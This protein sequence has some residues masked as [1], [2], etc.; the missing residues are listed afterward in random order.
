MQISDQGLTFHPDGFKTYNVPALLT[1]VGAIVGTMS[2]LVSTDGCTA[3]DT[4]AKLEAVLR[5][6][7]QMR[8]SNWEWCVNHCELDSVFLFR[9]GKCNSSHEDLG[10]MIF[11]HQLVA[12]WSG[13]SCQS[14]CLLRQR[15]RH[16]HTIPSKTL[17]AAKHW[18][19][20]GHQE[21]SWRI[22]DTLW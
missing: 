12:F 17:R 5:E 10:S 11:G 16:R 8:Y 13:A 1:T 6:A 4:F 3:T 22:L 9:Y 2:N 15:T 14:S 19:S 18:E 21:S 7:N 20:R